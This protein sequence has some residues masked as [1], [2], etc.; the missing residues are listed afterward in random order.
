[1]CKKNIKSAFD[2]YY[3]NETLKLKHNSFIQKWHRNIAL[4][5][6]TDLVKNH[7]QIIFFSDYQITSTDDTYICNNREHVLSTQCYFIPETNHI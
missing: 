1:M 4:I 5:S 7:L 3:I 6:H 2:L